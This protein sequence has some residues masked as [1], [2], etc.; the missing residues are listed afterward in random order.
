MQRPFKEKMP[1]KHIHPTSQKVSTL[2]KNVSPQAIPPILSGQMFQLI[3][4][5]VEEDGL[6]KAKCL[7]CDKV[8]A[9]SLKSSTNFKFHLKRKHKKEFDLY[10]TQRRNSS[11]GK[12][13]SFNKLP[14]PKPIKSECFDSDN[15]IQ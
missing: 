3:G 6:C 8:Y 1:H 4:E 10:E 5:S 2:D 9:G 14:P 12:L 13:K 15:N 11:V 7:L